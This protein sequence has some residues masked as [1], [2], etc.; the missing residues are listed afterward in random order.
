MDI[1]KRVKKRTTIWSSNHFWIFY[2]PHTKKLKSA[3]PRDAFTPTFITALFIMTKKQKQ[4]RCPLMNEWRLYAYNGK[5]FSLK[6]QGHPVMHYNMNEIW[7]HYADGNKQ[8]PE[9]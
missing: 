9:G 1:L 6:K 4:A 5:L 8:I 3:S 7:R 2:P